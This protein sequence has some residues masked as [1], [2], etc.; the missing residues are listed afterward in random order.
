MS[1]IGLVRIGG[2]QLRAI[3]EDRREAVIAFKESECQ[4]Y[5]RLMTTRS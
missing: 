5:L 3:S 1:G 2:D 4:K